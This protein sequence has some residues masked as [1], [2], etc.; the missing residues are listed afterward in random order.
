MILFLI[1]PYKVNKWQL[2]G[3]K[4]YKKNTIYNR[5]YQLSQIAIL[6]IILRNKILVKIGVNHKQDK[7]KNICQCWLIT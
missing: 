5:N 6:L 3:M 2:M 1:N 4:K 7:I